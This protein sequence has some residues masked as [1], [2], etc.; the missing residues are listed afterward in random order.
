VANYTVVG[1]N[2]EGNVIISVPLGAVDQDGQYLD[3]MTVVN[4][5]RAAVAAAPGVQLVQARK[6]EQVITIV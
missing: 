6:Y 3:D 5:V 4:A 2:N 1:K